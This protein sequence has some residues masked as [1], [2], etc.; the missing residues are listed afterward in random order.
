MSHC[1]GTMHSPIFLCMPSPLNKVAGRSL[2][3]STSLKLI[4]KWV[5][6]RTCDLHQRD[7]KNFC[8]RLLNRVTK[9]KMIFTTL[10]LNG[11]LTTSINLYENQ[12]T[13]INLQVKMHNR[14]DNKMFTHNI[15]LANYCCSKMKKENWRGWK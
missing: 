14:T 8:S 4:S 10:L 3:A 7:R 12:Q 6:N 11:L 5:G 1:T 9:L 2:F 13:L 15:V